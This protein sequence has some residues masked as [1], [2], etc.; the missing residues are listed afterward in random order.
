MKG[1]YGSLVGGREPWNKVDEMTMTRQSSE[2][3]DVASV[4]SLNV[5][6]LPAY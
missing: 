5:L 3:L 4:F 2:Y 6:L 1:R